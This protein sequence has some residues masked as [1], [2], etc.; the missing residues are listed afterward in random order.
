MAEYI[1]EYCG[2]AN[3]PLDRLVDLVRR[4]EIDGP[5]FA[6]SDAA[7]IRT[8]GDDLAAAQLHL[9][10]H[11]HRHL[12]TIDAAPF[13]E[14]L[15][16]TTAAR[17]EEVP[18][19]FGPAGS[20]SR[21]EVVGREIARGRDGILVP[22]HDTQQ[23]KNY[24]AKLASNEEAWLRECSTLRQL[25]SLGCV[26]S[27]VDGFSLP[28]DQF[29]TPFRFVVILEKADY[30]LTIELQGGRPVEA[31][32]RKYLI[33]VLMA[34]LREIHHCQVCHGDFKPGNVLAV[35][36][37]EQWKLSDFDHS[38]AFGQPLTAGTVL[39]A[40]PELC[41]FLLHPDQFPAPKG[42]VAIDVWCLGMT[43][44]EMLLGHH[45]LNSWPSEQEA[46]EYVAGLTESTLPLPPQLENGGDALALEFLR[47]CL[48]VKP[49]ERASLRDLQIHPWVAGAATIARL[50]GDGE[51]RRLELLQKMEDLRQL[52]EAHHL[53]VIRGQ[54]RA[55]ESL[56]R[57][58]TL[59]QNVSVLVTM[60]HKQDELLGLLQS[61]AVNLDRSAL[62]SLVRSLEDRLPAILGQLPEHMRKT[63][64]IEEA[65]ARLERCLGEN[66]EDMR[67]ELKSLKDTVSDV[68]SS[69]QKREI[70]GNVL[71]LE[72]DA[73][74][75]VKPKRL[76][77]HAKMNE[78]TWG[79]TSL[80]TNHKDD[81]ALHCRP[82]H[83][84]K[85]RLEL[86]V[87]E[88]SV[89]TIEACDSLRLGNWRLCSDYEQ[90]TE[91]NGCEIVLPV[92]RIV[93]PNIHA[94]LFVVEGEIPRDRLP[95]FMRQPHRRGSR[96]RVDLTAVI[97]V[98]GR[99]DAIT[100]SV[101]LSFKVKE[102]GSNILRPESDDRIFARWWAGASAAARA[103]FVVK[104]ILLAIALAGVL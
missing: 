70:A 62:L 78:P 83:R 60:S 31:S 91:V 39:Y 49:E 76:D 40:P 44:L 104:G 26:I 35:M 27:S 9:W 101:C 84:K 71:Y 73:R 97:R 19:S 75:E 98:S 47:M 43:V 87:H 22:V 86:V 20:P 64:A 33:R 74:G 103:A 8:L 79:H 96:V 53:H 59:E 92:T 56:E 13:A 72:D 37:R 81:P 77:E 5:V 21:Y 12:T 10:L 102:D 57:L 63:E 46:G 67:K 52:M 38:V 18:P 2:R 42:S 28:A 4:K 41:R 16:P 93:D 69:L 61:Q 88:D 1:R 68:Q 7:F 100:K 23:N 95:E 80:N 29:G 99:N 82:S 11:L 90:V 32:K 94:R 15:S 48:A 34:A 58:A 89:F 36:P 6:G 30:P 55:A 66:D 14:V 85:I 17:L 65:C 50:G 25:A 54:V 45:P 51:R 3:K 24:V